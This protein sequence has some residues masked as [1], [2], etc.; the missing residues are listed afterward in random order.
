MPQNR[1]SWL[2]VKLGVRMLAKNPGLTLVGGLAIAVAVAV[3]AA[4]FT[5]IHSAMFPRLPLDEG[6]RIV[7]L[8]NHDI[9]KDNE[10]R[11]SL[12]DLAVWRTEMRT[13]RDIGAFRTVQR[14]LIGA[15]GPPEPVEVAEMTASGFTLARVRPLRGRYLVAADERPDAPPVVVIGEEVWRRRFDGD[16]AIVGRT[17]RLGSTAHTVVGVMPERFGFPLSHTLWIPLRMDPVRFEPKTGP[18]YFVFGRLAPGVTRE[19][20]QAE[21][22]TL[23]RRAAA[24]WPAT[25]AGLEPRVYSYTEPILDIQEMTLWD[26]LP[27]QLMMTLLLG[28]VAVNVA[29]LVYARTASRLGELAV[30]SALG[31]TR[32]RIVAQLFAEMVVLALGASLVGLAVSQVGLRLATRAMYDDLGTGTPF[33]MDYTVSPLTVGWVVLLA[34]FTAVVAGV[35]PALQATGPRLQASLRRVSGGTQGGMGRMWTVMVVA[36]VGLAVAALPVA[37]ASGWDIVTDVDT[38]PVYDGAQYVTARVSSDFELPAGTDPEEHLRAVRDRFGALAPE[39]ARRLADEPG[40]SNVAMSSTYPGTEPARKLEVEDMRLPQP[41][42]DRAAGINQVDPGFFRA[43]GA[44]VLAG[45]AFTAADLDT[46][47]RA[48]VVNR[49]FVRDVLGGRSALGMRVRRAPDGSAGPETPPEPWM[50]IVGV[51]GDLEDNSLEEERIAARM[52]L[53]LRP[54]ATGGALVSLR[55]PGGPPPNFTGRLREIVSSVEPTLRVSEARTLKAEY[56]QH[57][58]VTQLVAAGI[59]LVMLSIFLLSAAGIYALMSFTVTQ[60]RK[61]IG[62]RSAL[63]A[64][65]R[66]LLASVFART[67]RQ[68]ALGIA[69]GMPLSFLYDVVE[70]EGL[71]DE[72]G[73]IAVPLVA[74]MM[75]ATGL[76]AAAGPARRGLRIEPSEALRADG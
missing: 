50:E 19:Q 23:G 46:T 36:Q 2:D 45:R 35:V 26:T 76:L 29:I 48:V 11:R 28:V 73:L 24:E 22:T 72:H 30:R 39:L 64:Q 38:R 32:A 59:G 66:R 71:M 1:I 25:H 75:L 57:V 53:P 65:P 47:S 10:E 4:T 41:S 18:E 27:L 62:I 69:L 70:N 8:E 13:V 6:D 55:M 9:K 37:V 7:A 15:G 21:L 52:Y 33:W 68:L 14:N 60:R 31:A 17:L 12:R 49:A 34:A 42:R 44:P 40:V 51:V 5:F 67:A 3:S 16:P 54:G 61:E 74:A 63:G 58:F 43:F 56:E 20:A